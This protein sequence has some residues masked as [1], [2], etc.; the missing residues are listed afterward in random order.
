M[1][2]VAF[3]LIMIKKG[4]R[5]KNNT[6]RTLLLDIATRTLMFYCPILLVFTVTHTTGP[7]CDW[8]SSVPQPESIFALALLDRRTGVTF[9]GQL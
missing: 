7:S 2:M 4:E 6:F 1:T 3:L 5:D 8:Y 9:L